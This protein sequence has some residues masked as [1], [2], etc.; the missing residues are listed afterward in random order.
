MTIASGQGKSD[1][2]LEKLMEIARKFDIADEFVV[3]IEKRLDEQLDTGSYFRIPATP[4]VAPHT[5][6]N[7]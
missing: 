6:K 2:P 4:R 7:L 3:P 1:I 5:E